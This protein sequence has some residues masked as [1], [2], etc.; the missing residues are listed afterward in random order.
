MDFS[1]RLME[2]TNHMHLEALADERYFLDKPVDEKTSQ[3]TLTFLSHLNQ[4]IEY[5][6][7]LYLAT[8]VSRIQWLK[9]GSALQDLKAEFLNSDLSTYPE[10]TPILAVW[11]S[12]WYCKKI[13]YYSEGAEEGTRYDDVFLIEAE[14]LEDACNSDNPHQFY[15][16]DHHDIEAI[17]G[18]FKEIG[19]P[20]EGYQTFIDFVLSGLDYSYYSDVDREYAKQAHPIIRDYIASQITM[21]RE[22]E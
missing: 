7:Q 17:E 9:T 20:D 16:M 2:E 11:S 22:E 12:A 3:L 1:R 15:H 5:E 18:G 6:H 19:L 4:K 14:V 13:C 21:H 8:N 10:G